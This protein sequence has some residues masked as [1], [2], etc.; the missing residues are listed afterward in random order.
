MGSGLEGFDFSHEGVK[1]VVGLVI[2]FVSVI[3]SAPY[4]FLYLKQR[5]HDIKKKR[6]KKKKVRISPIVPQV[7]PNS[8]SI[9]SHKAWIRFRSGNYA[10]HRIVSPLLRFP[11]RLAYPLWTRALSSTTVAPRI[12]L[13]TFVPK[14]HKVGIHNVPDIE[15]IVD[16]GFAW[17]KN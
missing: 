4:H 12:P 6:K 1:R 14:V 11:Y 16:L 5:I 13:T 8:F 3:A 7:S 9:S 10:G 17:D 15:R 2:G